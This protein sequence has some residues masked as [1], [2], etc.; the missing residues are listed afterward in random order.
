MLDTLGG[1]A[2]IFRVEGTAP[3]RISRRRAVQT[4]AVLDTRIL[5]RSQLEQQMA[6]GVSRR[7]AARETETAAA[8]GTL[9]RYQ[10][11]IVVLL[12]FIYCCRLIHF[13]NPSG[14]YTDAFSL[15]LLKPFL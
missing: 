10:V 1:R 6:G 13:D 11:F 12:W 15:Q 3:R 14:L 9:R 2:P 4:P 5:M 8:L 7:L